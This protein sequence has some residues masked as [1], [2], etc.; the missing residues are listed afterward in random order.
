MIPAMRSARCSERLELTAIASRRLETAQAVAQA[1]QIDKA[2]GSYE[3][4]LAD[5]DIDAV[6]IPLPNHLHV[7]F[8]LQSLE[9][10]KHVL[11]EKPIGLNAAEAQALADAARRSP[12][13]KVMEAFMYRLHPQWQWARQVVAE[14][15]IGDVRTI[16]STFSFYDDD[17]NSILHHPEWGGGA[18]MDIG[19]YSVSLSRF[20]FRVEPQRVLGVSEIDPQ[21]GVDRST[22]GILQ[23]ATGT[24]TFS[25]S[26]D[27]ALY[28]R[29]SIVGTGG[30][31]EIETPF[32]PPPDRP[33]R[34]W[35][36]VDGAAEE[37]RF[38]P[39][40][41]YGIQVDLF[42]QAILEDLPAPTPI[43][44]AVENMKV[45]D[46]LVR[47]SRRGAWENL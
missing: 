30:R 42:S 9:S 7:P 21:F 25:C 34:A 22:S 2:Y 20:L 44:D 24:A 5:P 45:I 26:T 8:A 40:D 3:A 1:S 4:L 38:E 16:H 47:S 13:L 33:C 28:Q 37:V 11:G 27:A 18:L 10:G 35:I 43:E 41:Q 46:A 15:R 19:C 6:Y 23:F 14:G 31:L 29:V 17:P 12:R 32:N 36:E 39:C